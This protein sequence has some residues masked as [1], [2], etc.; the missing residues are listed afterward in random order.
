M[1]LNII[2][3]I[4]VIPDLEQIKANASTGEVQTDRIPLRL[5]TL[6]ENAI[7]AAVQLREKHGGKVFGLIFGK[8]ESAPLMKKAYAMGVDEGT[9]LTGYGENNPMHTAEVLCQK[10][11]TMQFDLIISGNQ[12]ADTYTGL[13]P[14]I[15]SSK[16]NI[17]L[18]SNALT[19]SIDQA[20]ITVRSSLDRKIQNLSSQLPAIVSVTQETNQPRLPPV[21]QIMAAGRKQ[22]VTEAAQVADTAN[23]KR[24]SN[25]APKSERRK[26][27][28]EKTDEG[29]VAIVKAI[30]EEIR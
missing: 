16:L 1:P 8:Q 15:I 12:S 30:K 7:E 6:S 29:I 20:T 2:V 5:E 22:I 24:I 19:L 23:V 18:L 4:K 25:K 21:M 14:G 27:L 17:N 9:V 10:I 3:L 11:R 28:F 26:Q 13:L